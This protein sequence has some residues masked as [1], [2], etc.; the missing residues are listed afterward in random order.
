MPS[1]VTTFAFWVRQLRTTYWPR[2]MAIGSA[3][4]EAVGGATVGAVSG[5]TL[6]GGG[7]CFLWQPV[8]R[9]KAATAAAVTSNLRIDVVFKFISLSCK[10]GWEMRADSVGRSAQLDHLFR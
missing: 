1:M 9:P 7:P 3:V 5:P 10:A 4:I 2:S 8:A 6:L